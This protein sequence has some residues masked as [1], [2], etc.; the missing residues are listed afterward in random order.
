ML[1]VC[2]SSSPPSV[3]KGKKQYKSKH[4]HR[5]NAGGTKWLEEDKDPLPLF[6]LWGDLPQPLVLIGMSVNGSL[7]HFELDTGATATVN[8][9]KNVDSCF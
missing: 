3:N 9:N 4:Y 5:G 7:V 1:P 8:P 2:R 6:V